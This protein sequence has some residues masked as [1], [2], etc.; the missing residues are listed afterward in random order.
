MFVSVKKKINNTKQNSDVY[1][2]YLIFLRIK[3]LY[4]YIFSIS[5]FIKESIL[6]HCGAF[7]SKYLNFSAKVCMTFEKGEK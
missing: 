6:A 2:R 5:N 4:K 1:K 3:P 7:A